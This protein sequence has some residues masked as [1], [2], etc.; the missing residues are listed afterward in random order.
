MRAKAVD[1]AVANNF[2]KPCA[3]CGV[4]SGAEDGVDR[5]SRCLSRQEKHYSPG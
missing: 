4:G 1:I 5:G 2:E 3:L